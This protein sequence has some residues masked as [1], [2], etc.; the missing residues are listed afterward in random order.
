NTDCAP[1]GSGRGRLHPGDVSMTSYIT[2]NYGELALASILVLIDASLSI[3]FGLQ[4]HRSLLVAA[5]RMTVQLTLVGL[6]LTALFSVVSPLWTGVA[7][8]VM[9]LFAGREVMQRQDRRLSEIGRASCRE[10]V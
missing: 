4:I 8:L 2:L 10:R 3:I 7:V 5:I 6:V 1:A 9:V